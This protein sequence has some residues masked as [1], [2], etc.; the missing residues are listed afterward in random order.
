MIGIQI[1]VSVILLA[2]VCVGAYF[3]SQKCI[4]LF[5]GKETDDLEYILDTEC[6]PGRWSIRYA[7]RIEKMRAKGIDEDKIERVRQLADRK[8]Q[9]RMKR[10]QAFAKGAPIFENES[11]RN[12][13]I[14][15]LGR[16]KEQW[17]RR[18]FLHE[19]Y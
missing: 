18:E 10:I 8:F 9:R 1:L 5:L 4:E 19:P 3:Y 6:V 2:L 11:Y 7:R 13:V 14:E 16:I 17:K 12:V 15:D